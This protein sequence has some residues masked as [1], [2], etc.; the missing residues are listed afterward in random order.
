MEEFIRFPVAHK[1]ITCIV[2][3]GKIKKLVLS[4]ILCVDE[5]ADATLT[6]FMDM[7]DSHRN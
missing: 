4:F 6:G 1:N 5:W 3:I 2:V 7:G